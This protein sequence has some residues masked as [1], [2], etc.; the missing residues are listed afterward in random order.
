MV[1]N[2]SFR[3]DLFRWS[4]LIFSKTIKTENL[5]KR[6]GI[7]HFSSSAHLPISIATALRKLVSGSQS[8]NFE[9][10]WSGGFRVV[11]PHTTTLQ[12]SLLS[13]FG[14]FTTRYNLHRSDFRR[15]DLG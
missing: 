3:S 9:E 1:E 14:P 10:A 2:A 11:W 12:F 13:F 5:Q 15:G 7:L 8:A 4:R 6:C